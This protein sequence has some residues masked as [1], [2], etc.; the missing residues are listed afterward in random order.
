[1]ENS[2]FTLVMMAGLPGAGK[3]TLARQLKREIG[4]RVIDKDAYR[5]RLLSQGMDDEQAANDAYENSFSEIRMALLEQRTSVIFDTAAL[6]LFI[7]DTVKE[8][9]D[10]AADAQLKVILC[11]VDRDLR[12][13]RLRSRGEQ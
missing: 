6:H 4:W 7:L 10:C 2:R 1:M 9:V 3:T 8:I 13:E 5:V 12:N 11:V